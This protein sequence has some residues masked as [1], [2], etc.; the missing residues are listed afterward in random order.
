MKSKVLFLQLLLLAVVFG[1][2]V[3]LGVRQPALLSSIT[4]SNRPDVVVY[5]KD[6]Q[7]DTKIEVDMSLFW[8]V[9][10]LM[11]KNYLDMGDVKG[12]DLLYGAI[13]GMVSAAGDPYTSFFQPNDNVDFKEGLEGLYEGIGA[14][15]GYNDSKAL[16]VMAPLEGSPAE[17]AGV[18]AGDQILTVNEEDVAGWSIPKAVEAIRGDAGTEVTLMLYRESGD[19]AGTPF[20]VKVKREQIK[21][22]AVRLTYVD[23]KQ[24]AHLRVLRF[25]SDTITE[26]DKAVDE[27][28]KSGVKGV[29][30]DVR[31]NPGGYLNAAIHL[32]SEFFKDGVVVKRQGIDGVQEFKVNHQ[33]RLCEIPVVVLINKGSASASEIL[34][35]SIQ[36]RGRGKLIGEN[37]FG[38]GTVQE[39]IE[40]RSGTSLHV[41]TARWLMP[42][43][44][45]IHK[46]G[47]KPE[48][49]VKTEA[50]SGPFGDG[51]DDAQ[52]QKA[53]ESLR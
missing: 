46:V 44:K 39:A 25:G 53:I 38:K 12:D 22:P 3:Y 10:G 9:L 35:G 40:L 18:R 11:E 37:S 13:N 14:Q 6:S 47:L 33:C 21:L 32:A 49:E 5:N 16:V 23:N 50:A 8:E 29:I 1:G 19:K 41:T 31:N 51:A 45:N 52:L 27:L 26:W 34:A 2:G 24:Y 4:G 42:D 43:D 7:P 15:L 48:V 20:E 28:T 36:A 17:K 30:L